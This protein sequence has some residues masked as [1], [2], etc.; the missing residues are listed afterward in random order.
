[1]AKDREKA[2]EQIGF[3]VTPSFRSRVEDRADEEGRTMA[4]LI[5][6]VVNDYLD[7]VDD[8]K[9]LLKQ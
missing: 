1:M 9:K 4:N 2:T 5:I 3:R 8:A 7:Q 6:K